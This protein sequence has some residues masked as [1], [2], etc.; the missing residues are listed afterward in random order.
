M[1]P[2]RETARI[3]VVDDEPTTL[4]LVYAQLTDIGYRNVTLCQ[5]PRDAI[6]LVER[7]RPHV[8][9]LDIVMPGIS[10]FDILRSVRRS[11]TQSM[12]PVII[13]T[14]ADDF[15]TKV[16]ALELGA[17]DFL[18]KPVNF[19]ELAPRIRNAILVKS[20]HDQLQ[21]HAERLRRQVEV[22][23]ADLKRS[24]AALEQ[25]NLILQRSCE[26]AD[27]ATRAKSEFLAKVSH[28]LRTPLTS[29]IGFSEELLIQV[30]G[31]STT[32][33]EVEM[34]ETILRNARHLLSVVN[35][36]LD[37]TRIEKGRLAIERTPCN[38]AEL[39]AEVTRLME[40][41]AKAKGLPLRSESRGPIPRAIL[42]DPT[43]LRQILI[44]IVNNAIKFTETGSVSILMQMLGD[45]RAA[46][47]QFEVV[48][49]GI[50]IECAEQG[51]I[52]KPFVQSAKTRSCVYGGAGLGLTICK[53]L[54]EELGGTIGLESQPGRGSTF[55]VVVAAETAPS[56]ELTNEAD[57]LHGG[58][59]AAREA[60]PNSP[61]RILLA[62]D[63]VDNQRLIRV[64]LEKSGSEVTVVDNGQKALQTALEAW[65]AERPFDVVLTDIQM[66]LLNGYELTERL[67][68]SG[69]DGRIVA[70]TAHAMAGERERCL[71]AGCDSYLTKPI[72]RAELLAE[73][74]VVPAA[75]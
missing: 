54:A 3:L 39:L 66:P 60:G 7:Q 46:L 64:I 47:L 42:T 24:H 56:L 50:G 44:N 15:A 62:E 31:G 2:E 48:D 33:L 29:I 52:F 28:E 75:V 22:Q 58:A 18:G 37:M 55:R 73:V 49:T 6:G 43:R 35:D 57:S 8:L 21:E 65:H 16:Q 68:A 4:E 51:E 74:A 11:S 12:L 59:V 67:R 17:T 34:L 9:L 38:P 69:Y 10:G 72:D 40:P 5:D 1:R 20:Y 26:A 25:A 41:Q 32:P 70:L 14:V 71:A 36:V 13:L 45:P 63:C 27:A 19:V 61:R 30:G 23:T 53:Y